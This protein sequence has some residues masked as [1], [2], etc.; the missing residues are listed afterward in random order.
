[1]DYPTLEYKLTKVA[2]GQESYISM[3]GIAVGHTDELVNLE[4]SERQCYLSDECNLKFYRT[5]SHSNCIQEC[6]LEAAYKQFGCLPWTEP[7]IYT[8]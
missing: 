3:S 2:P 8:K 6:R 7:S 5:Y 1:M 4:P